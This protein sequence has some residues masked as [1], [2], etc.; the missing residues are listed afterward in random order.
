MLT[1][2]AVRR[3]L[4]FAATFAIQ[5]YS[6]FDGQQ[7]SQGHD[8]RLRKPHQPRK[9]GCAL[10]FCQL[11]AQYL[12]RYAL[13]QFLQALL[14]KVERKLGRETILAS[15]F[16]Q[17]AHLLGLQVTYEEKASAFAF[18]V[19]GERSTSRCKLQPGLLPPLLLL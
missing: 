15:Q 16:Q 12:V 17:A 11:W 8:M 3:R 9:L 6:A 14:R 7:Q 13:L 18:D 5:S 19:L 4:P 2:P 10:C 1:V